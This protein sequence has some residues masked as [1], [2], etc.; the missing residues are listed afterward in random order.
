MSSDVDYRY[1]GKQNF[2][3]YLYPSSKEMTKIEL[4][5]IFNKLSVNAVLE[6]GIHFKKRKLFA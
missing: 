4:H 6:L 1:G 5:K 2:K 3:T